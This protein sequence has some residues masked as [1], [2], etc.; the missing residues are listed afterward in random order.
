MLPMPSAVQNS[1]VRLLGNVLFYTIAPCGGLEC[2]I[3]SLL[4]SVCAVMFAGTA[5]AAHG[6]EGDYQ[7]VRDMGGTTHE[8]L[9]K[10]FRA[11]RNVG[12]GVA[13][14][15]V[16]LRADALHP[17]ARRCGSQVL[18]CSLILRSGGYTPCSCGCDGR[19]KT[20]RR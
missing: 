7:R 12:A 14:R 19:T 6:A 9:N 1:F 13:V 17:R 11:E 18:R 8:L 20:W 2:S 10:K 5:L 15:S 4:V 3:A 16:P